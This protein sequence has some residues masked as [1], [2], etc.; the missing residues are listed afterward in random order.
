MPENEMEK[1]LERAAITIR[2][3]C[4]GPVAPYR[5]GYIVDALRESGLLRLLEAGQQ[6]RDLLKAEFPPPHKILCVIEHDAAKAA[7]KEQAHA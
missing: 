2:R 4:P 6:C 1:V 3:H 5:I 7:I